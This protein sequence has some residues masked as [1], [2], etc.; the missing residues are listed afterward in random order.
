MEKSEQDYNLIDWFKKVVLNN[1]VNFDGRARRKEYWNFILAYLIIYIPLYVITLT[2]MGDTGSFGIIGILL[3][4]FAFGMLLPSLG[5]AIRRLHD[6]DKSGW[7]LLINFIPFGAFYV[8]YLLVTEG[9]KGP[10]QYGSD[11]KGFGSEIHEIG[12]TQE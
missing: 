3:M 11:P 7:Y 2:S 4:L 9:T 1:Y 6:V 10:N 5:V 8:L 12:I